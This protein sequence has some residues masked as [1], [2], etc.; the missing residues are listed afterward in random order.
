MLEKNMVISF[1]IKENIL[2]LLK[3]NAEEFT[4]NLRFL[5]VIKNKR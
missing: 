3:E 1:S 5:V 4:Q 2:L